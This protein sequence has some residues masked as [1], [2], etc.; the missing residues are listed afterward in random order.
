MPAKSKVLNLY[1]TAGLFDGEGHVSI[2][3]DLKGMQIG[4][5]NTNLDILE[6]L[7][8]QY[9]GRIEELKR[10]KPTH[11]RTWHWIISKKEEFVKFL[12]DIEMKVKIKIPQVFAAEAFTLTML[13]CGGNRRE[14]KERLRKIDWEM[15][16]EALSNLRR[17]NSARK[18][19]KA[20]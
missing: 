4:I 18:K 3:R 19:Q 2:R 6:K 10:Y 12:K 20:T 1:Y 17:F 7:R 8:I 16:E 9:G 5:T 14:G 11:S 15:R 13:N